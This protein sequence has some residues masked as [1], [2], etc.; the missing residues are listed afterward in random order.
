MTE[1]FYKQRRPCLS[2]EELNSVGLELHAKTLRL[3]RELKKSHLPERF[4][5]TDLV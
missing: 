5:C 3:Q 2:L 1:T 4:P